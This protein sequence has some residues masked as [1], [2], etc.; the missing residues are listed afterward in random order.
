[1]PH[2]A[3]RQKCRKKTKKSRQT[4]N[5]RKNMAME[6]KNRGI[7]CLVTGGCGFIG[8][9]VLNRLESEGIS[10][11]CLDIAEPKSN[12]C[13]PI[14][15]D[16]L[17]DKA[18]KGIRGY[19]TV[20]H[21]AGMSNYLHCEK[22]PQ[23]AERIN[24]E[25]TRK[26]LENLKDTERFLLLSTVM[27]YADDAGELDEN[28][29]TRPANVYART[30]LSAEEICEKHA[31]EHG[32]DYTCLRLT[33]VYGPGMRKE[34]AIRK[35]IEQ[36]LDNEPITVWGD[37]TQNRNFVYASDAACAITEAMKLSKGV[38]L[39]NIA[40]KESISVNHV[41]SEIGKNIQGLKREHKPHETADMK[42]LRIS[43][44]KAETELGYAPRMGFQ[45]G[46]KRCVESIKEERAGQ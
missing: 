1:M 7:S 6:T 13:E 37:G 14:R 9:Y 25:G 11:G 42:N 32:M 46:I 19:D 20:I 26:V 8:K 41:L 2:N 29:Q 44:K 40:G 23:M 21:L 33:S 18:L 10:A 16:I 45:E 22:N 36:A 24:T 31:K 34:L 28:A 4:K 27:V 3:N 5:D 30:K 17:D 15:A 12:G 35:F 39:Y 38:K 43:I